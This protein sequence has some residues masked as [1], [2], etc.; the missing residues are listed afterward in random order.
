MSVIETI[1]E[2][3]SFNF[4]GRINILKATDG[5]F[6]GV[7]HM[8]SGNVVSAQYAKRTGETALISLIIVELDDQLKIRLVVEPEI[9]NDTDIE[10]TMAV[11][12]IKQRAKKSYEEHL[13]TKKLRP[14][15]ELR[16]L[17]NPN[18]I[19]Q[20][21]NPDLNE[22]TLLKNMVEFSK[23]EQLYKH[24]DLHEFEITKALVGLRK[25]NAIKVIK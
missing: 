1:E 15:N 19:E 3:S 14:S 12:E 16:L 4:T 22:F 6:L 13:E 24:T 5:Q 2:Q 9:V 11:S 10:F 25:K 21:V 23:V 18:Y 7:I 17:I 8:L 20:G